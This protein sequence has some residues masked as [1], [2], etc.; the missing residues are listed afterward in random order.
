M[1][2]LTWVSASFMAIILAGSSVN[3]FAAHNA[4][5]KQNTPSSSSQSEE[6]VKDVATDL[7]NEAGGALNRTV[8]DAADVVKR[9]GR[10]LDDGFKKVTD[11]SQSNKK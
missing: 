7:L 11:K 5:A 4:K 6:S 2:T 10:H 3:T 9:V 1:K 8:N